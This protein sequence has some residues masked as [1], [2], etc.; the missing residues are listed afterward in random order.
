MLP[1]GVPAELLPA[2]VFLQSCC[3]QWYFCRHI[4]QQRLCRPI[5][6]KGVSAELEPTMLHD[7]S[8]QGGVFR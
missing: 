4:L 7:S 2:K 3:L 5:A 6:F 1:T 8:C